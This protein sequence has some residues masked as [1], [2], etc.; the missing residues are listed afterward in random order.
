MCFA[1]IEEMSFSGRRV[2]AEPAAS[3]FASP[4]QGDSGRLSVTH[5]C[6]RSA[7]RGHPRRRQ[8]RSSP[9]ASPALGPDQGKG[10]EAL[11]ASQSLARHETRRHQKT[12]FSPAARNFWPF[13][14][15][16]S[17]LEFLAPGVSSASLAFPSG[18][19]GSAG[20]T[21]GERRRGW[22]RIGRRNWS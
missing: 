19:R 1:C 21:E 11:A 7:P 5:R 20:G 22:R 3:V 13:R 10:K 15:P 6:D 17:R 14:P 12:F 4:G 16:R 18:A 9:P 2:R 8:R